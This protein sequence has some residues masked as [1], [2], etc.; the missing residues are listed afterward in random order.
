MP[1]ITL[2]D[3]P[4]DLHAQLKQEAEAHFRSVNQEALARIQRSFDWDDRLS[5]E[6]VNGWIAEAMASGPEEALS[7]EKFDAARDQARRKLADRSRAA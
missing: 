1:S 7:R 6:R 2:T 5:A 4:E 3:I